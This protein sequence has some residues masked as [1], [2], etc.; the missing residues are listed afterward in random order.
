MP[1]MSVVAVMVF[2]WLIG[3]THGDTRSPA[4]KATKAIWDIAQLGL[5]D[6]TNK[7]YAIN[8]G[9]VEVDLSGAGPICPTGLGHLASGKGSVRS[10]S[11]VFDCSS[12]GEHW[13]HIRWTPGGSGDEQFAVY[14]SDEPGGK[15]RLVKAAETPNAVIQEKFR[16][17]LAKG[18]VALTLKHLSGDGLRFQQIAL[19]RSQQPPRA[20]RPD[21]KYPTLASYER[22]I[23]EPGLMLDGEHVT[24]FAPKIRQAQARAVFGRLTRA[25]DALYNT[26]GV[27]TPYKIVVYHFPENHRDARGGTSNCVIWYSYKNLDPKSWEEWRRYKVPHVC[28]YIEEMAHNFVSASGTQFGWEMIGWSI[29]VRATEQVAPNPVFARQVAGT[30]RNQAKT[31][32]RY[33]RGGKTFPRNLPGNQV[34]RIH[35]HVLNLCEQRY[36]PKFWPDFFAEIRKAQGQIRRARQISDG[37]KRR[38][39]LYVISLDCF[40]RL[41]GIKLKS[42]L[43]RYQISLTTDV[44]SLNPTDKNWDRRLLAPGERSRD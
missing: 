1:K 35:A 23:R 21:L 39:A 32:G 14:V 20:T 2:A 44:K 28:G 13:L 29:G 42:F 11:L 37:S 10:V 31:F 3:V 19:S 17:R 16:L 33:V 12:S 30:R 9:L 7:A 34:D 41:E 4:N 40:D 25:Y 43:K 8:D 5:F 36:G 22:T 6:P 15:T 18:Q 38:D 27:H 24:L 26:V